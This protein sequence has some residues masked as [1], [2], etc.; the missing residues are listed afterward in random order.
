MKVYF[1]RISRIKYRHYILVYIQHIQYNLF[2][3]R[4]FKY[5]PCFKKDEVIDI[6]KYK[7]SVDQNKCIGCGACASICNNFKLKEGR[8]SP[9]KAEIDEIGCSGEARDSCPVGA[10]SVE[11]I[12]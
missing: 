6:A 1:Q 7:V 8:S 4:N 10:I 12:K 5:N 2:V 3:Y 11:E 9:K